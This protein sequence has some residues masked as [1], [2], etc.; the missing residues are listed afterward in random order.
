MATIYGRPP[1]TT[2]RTVQSLTLAPPTTQSR[3]AADHNAVAFLCHSVQLQEQLSEIVTKLYADRDDAEIDNGVPWP[4]VIEKPSV[5]PFAN[6]MEAGNFVT[7]EAAIASWESRL[8]DF[9]RLP[10]LSE[11]QDKP[12][13]IQQAT[14][15]CVVLRAQ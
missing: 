6:Y 11:L 12:E 15:Q 13:M 3:T 1:L 14:Q 2:P 4:R 10:P 8:P 7:I 5:Q 9:L